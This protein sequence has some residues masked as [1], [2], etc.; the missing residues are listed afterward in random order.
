MVLSKSGVYAGKRTQ[1]R[2]R[3]V[4]SPFP[5]LFHTSPLHSLN[6]Q[7]LKRGCSHGSSEDAAG[8]GPLGAQIIEVRTPLFSP[9]GKKMAK[10]WKTHLT[11]VLFFC[12]EPIRLIARTR[13]IAISPQT[14][15]AGV[16]DTCRS[17]RIP[18]PFPRD[19]KSRLSVAKGPQSK[20]GIEPWHSACS[21]LIP[22]HLLALLSSVPEAGRR[23]KPCG[24]LL[25]GEKGL[26]RRRAWLRD[27][28]IRQKGSGA[29]GCVP[30]R[31]C[32]ALWRRKAASSFKPPNRTTAWTNPV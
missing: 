22:K 7:L 9:F 6:C 23:T 4:K 25:S 28:W 16:S 10:I 30:A 8:P 31:V 3:E 21:I 26:R 17:P 12:Q 32:L 27:T 5:L 11:A 2:P 14:L 18:E 29:F 19:R 20:S 1:Q 13:K 15:T 24:W